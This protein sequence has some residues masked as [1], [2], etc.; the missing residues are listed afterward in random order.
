M[1]DLLQRVKQAGF[2]AL[3]VTLDIPVGAKRNRE[4][5]KRTEAAFWFLARVLYGN[6]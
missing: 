1:K 3:V 5:K 2:Q 6:V 4:L